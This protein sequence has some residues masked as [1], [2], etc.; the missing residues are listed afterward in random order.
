MMYEMIDKSDSRN[1]VVFCCGVRGLVGS[2]VEKLL[3]LGFV[4]EREFRFY[5]QWG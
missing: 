3:E 1:G 4:I 5:R 2:I